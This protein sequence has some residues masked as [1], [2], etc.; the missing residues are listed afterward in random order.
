MAEDCFLKRDFSSLFEA[1]PFY[2]KDFFSTQK[3]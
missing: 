1:A 3:A 2:T